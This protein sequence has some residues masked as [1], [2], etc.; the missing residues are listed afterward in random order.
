MHSASTLLNFYFVCQF[1]EEGEN[2]EEEKK[3]EEE[4]QEEECKFLLIFFSVFF[5]LNFRHTRNTFHSI[6]QQESFFEPGGFTSLSS[7]AVLAR[8]GG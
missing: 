2:P 5:A 3:P 8:C 6:W 7:G 4:E 1:Q